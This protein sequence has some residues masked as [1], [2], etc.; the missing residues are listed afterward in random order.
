MP[1]KSSAAVFGEA[2]R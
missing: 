1:P 2:G